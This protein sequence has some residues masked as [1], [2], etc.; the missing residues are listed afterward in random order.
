M[1][2]LSLELLE[3]LDELCKTG[4]YN[5]SPTIFFCVM[6]PDDGNLC[7]F[8]KHK[9]NFCYKFPDNVTFEEGALVEPL[10][11]GIHACRQ[12]GNKVLVCGAGPDGLVS[13]SQPRRWVQ[14][15]WWWLIC[16]PLG[17]LKP[18]K[19]GLISSS[20]LQWEPS[21]NSQESRR[22]SG[23]QAAEDTWS[24]HTGRRNRRELISSR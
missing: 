23:Q 10:S 3:K 2:T 16:Q 12:T 17:C 7:Q 9:A 22:S 19:L 24:C 5:L 1:L 20:G 18:R 13:S 21:G 6:P 8:Y 11:V 4:R 15:K 14:L